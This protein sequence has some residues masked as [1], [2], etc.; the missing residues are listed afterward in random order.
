MEPLKDPKVKELFEKIGEVRKASAHLSMEGD[1]APSPVSNDD[2]SYI[3]EPSDAPDTEADGS[4]P[5]VSSLDAMLAQQLGGL[6]LDG[7]MTLDQQ[8]EL[9]DLLSSIE[10]LEIQCAPKSKRIIGNTY[11]S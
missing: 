4:A 10:Q 2:D 1:E 6:S 7:E 9:S 8:R 11:E 5:Q 3:T